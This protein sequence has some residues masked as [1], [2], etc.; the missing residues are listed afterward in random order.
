MKDTFI[1]LGCDTVIKNELGVKLVKYLTIINY[2]RYKWY[3]DEYDDINLGREDSDFRKGDNITY[4][5]A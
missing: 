5:K 1:R 3:E 4:E 2:E